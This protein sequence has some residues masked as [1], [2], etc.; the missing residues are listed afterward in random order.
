MNETT[1]S[2]IKDLL[3]AYALG[4]LDAAEAAQVAAHLATCPACRDELSAYETV[5]DLLATAVP[6]TT[7]PPALKSKLM[8]RTQTAVRPPV[9]TRQQSIKERLQSLWH[10][11]RWQAALAVAMLA[12]VVTALF[13]WQQNRPA[14]LSQFTLTATEYAPGAAG[15]ISLA[16]DGTATL[17][18]TNLPPLTAEQQYQLWLIRDG[19]RDSGAVFSVNADGSA[20]VSIQ[21]AR[22]LTAYSAFGITIEPAGGS[23]G[24]TGERVLGFNL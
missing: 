9:P 24:P 1:H 22:P 8:A 19:E 15:L 6:F 18:I 11:P 7:P 4:S 14:T 20:Q 17:T 12:L 2:D 5:T 21:V 10:R 16:A 13:I 3:P 23:P